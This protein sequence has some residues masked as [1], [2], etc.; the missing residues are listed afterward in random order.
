MIDPAGP[1]SLRR[2]TVDAAC[3]GD[4]NLLPIVGGN[5]LHEDSELW[6]SEGARCLPTTTAWTT[7]PEPL[8]TEVATREATG[9]PVHPP[10]GCRTN[11]EPR[12]K[13]PNRARSNSELRSKLKCHP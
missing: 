13:S 9:V 10:N 2:L 11:L 4:R 5:R 8:V 6:L 12:L 1:P 7:S 3:I